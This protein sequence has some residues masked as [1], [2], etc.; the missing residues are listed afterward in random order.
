MRIL[1]FAPEIFFGERFRELFKEYTSADLE[2]PKVDYKV[3][4]RALPFRE[5]EFDFIFASHV[6]EHIKEDSVA[7]S[8]VKRILKPHGIAVLPVPIRGKETV[9]YSK[10]NPQESNHVRSPGIDYFKRYERY[11]SKVKVYSSNDYPEKYQLVN[12]KVTDNYS[13]GSRPMQRKVVTIL[14]DF[15]PVCIV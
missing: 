1:H 12:Y 10:P 9:E 4:L 7:L 2:A 14:T 5:E 3:D 15:V 13:S 8:E 11:F 6:L